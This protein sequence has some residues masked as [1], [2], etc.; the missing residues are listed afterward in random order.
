MC[1]PLRSIFSMQN[2]QL[3]AGAHLLCE[4]EALSPNPKHPYS[5][6]QVACAVCNSSIGSSIGDRDRQMPGACLPP[7]MMCFMFSEKWCLKT[8]RERAIEE[9]TSLTSGCMCVYL[10]YTLPPI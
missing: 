7:K 1:K 2:Q 5:V 4:Q 6:R 8:K 9:E 3:A 10:H